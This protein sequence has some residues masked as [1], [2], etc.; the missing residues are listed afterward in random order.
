MK[1][2]FKTFYSLNDQ[3]YK[4]LWENC[5]FVFDANVLL[6]LYRYTDS[7]KN[8]LLKIFEQIKDRIWLPYQVT[9]EYHFNR[10]T[11]IQSQ[12][13]SYESISKLIEKKSIKLMNDLNEELKDYKKRHPRIDVGSII[14]S[15]DTSFSELASDIKKLENDHPDYFSGEDLILS[16]I[17]E[18]FLGKV[19]DNYD[20]KKLNEIYKNGENR[21]KADI[22]RYSSW[23]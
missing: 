20:Q 19:G 5:I 16:A 17:S 1:N 21:Y 4:S 13:D 3:D 8:Q 14:Q 15:L 18:L 6:N 2:K 9:L 22:S 10:L 23:L 11:V 12:V 7:T